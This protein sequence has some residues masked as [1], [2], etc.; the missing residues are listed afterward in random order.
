[1]LVKNIMFTVIHECY[2]MDLIS[3]ITL[4]IIKSSNSAAGNKS[5][6]AEQF[7]RAFIDKL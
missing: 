2:L 3:N 6:P 4:A 1:M 5:R 7:Q